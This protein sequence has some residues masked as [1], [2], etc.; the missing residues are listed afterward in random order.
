MEREFDMKSIALAC[1]IT[2]KSSL[3]LDGSTIVMVVAISLLDATWRQWR[4]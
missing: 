2:N 1:A 3:V 4:Q